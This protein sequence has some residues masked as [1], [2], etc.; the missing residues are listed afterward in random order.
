MPRHHWT[1]EDIRIVFATCKTHVD[2]EDRLQ[3]LKIYF[4]DCSIGALNFQIMRYQKRNDNTLR[5]IPEQGIFEGYGAN[6]RL[7]DEVWNE[8]N[9]KN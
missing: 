7:H 5:W 4:P 2:K 9:W 1:K 8:R 3:I 6:G